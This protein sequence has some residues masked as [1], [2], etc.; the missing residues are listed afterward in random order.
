MNSAT[1]DADPYIAP[2][3]SYI[4]FASYGRPESAGDGD[5]YVSYNRN[6]NWSRARSLQHDIGP[7]SH[8]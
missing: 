8:V 3:E 4:V 1:H 6:G 7:S 5:L 2:D